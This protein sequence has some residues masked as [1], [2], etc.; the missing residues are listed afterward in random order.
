MSSNPPVERVIDLYRLLVAFNGIERQ[1]FLPDTQQ[2]K[3]HAETDTEHSYALAMLAWFVANHFPHLDTNKCIQYALAHDIVELHA[4]DT[5]A[6]SKD[7]AVHKS[8]QQREQAAR[9]KLAETWPDFSELHKAI[10]AYE[11]REDAESKFVYALDKLAPIVLNVVA[12]G[13]AWHMHGIDIR[14]LQAYKATKV[15]VSPEIEALYK[16]LI[17]ILEAHPEYFPVKEATS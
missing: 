8:K 7:L 3:D 13:K 5:F 16:E 9:R 11:A 1:V 4:G 10:A 2:H 14:E 12:K 6:F 15:A 17:D